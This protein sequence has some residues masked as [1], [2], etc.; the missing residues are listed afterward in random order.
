[1]PADEMLFDDLGAPDGEDAELDRV[2]AWFTRQPSLEGRFSA[3][4]RQ[5]IDEVLDG[6]RTARY[7]IRQ[8]AKTEK[9]Y[10]GTKVEIVCQSE[11]GLPRGLEMDYSV[12]GVD[13]DAKFSLTGQWM[14]PKEAIG[15]ICLLLSADDQ[16]S[17]Y[18]AGLVR[19]GERILTKGGNRDGKR[20]I[21]KPGRSA[22][23][24]LFEN[25]SMRENLL[26]KLGHGVRAGIMA[27][28]AGQR[29]V[30]ELFRRVQGR[31]ID[32]NAV[33][34]VA[35]QLDSAKRVR[36][37]RKRL[38]P[39]GVIILGA[40]GKDPQIARSLGL[41]VPEKG[42]WLAVRLTR[43]EPSDSRLQ[44]DIGGIHYAVAEAGQ[45]YWPAPLIIAEGSRED[46]A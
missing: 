30:D 25:G 3:V 37:A 5:S 34:T 20:S 42:T 24:W 32:R 45:P 23:R 15:H 4:L 40:Q 10:L 26:L 27:E 31:I 14:I 12:S 21:S 13:V 7:D 19:I 9:T 46:T 39:E 18:V 29:R 43:A 22:I 44:V 38:Q 28:P 8:L 36:D 33:V 1:M 6:Q 11:F 2:A 16:N 41:T 17:S 35:K